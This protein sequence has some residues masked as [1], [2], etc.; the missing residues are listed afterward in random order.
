M[1]IE[2]FLVYKVSE[3]VQKH[4][5][6]VIFRITTK[7][8]LCDNMMFIYNVTE[9]KNCVSLRE[10]LLD[11]TFAENDAAAYAIESLLVPHR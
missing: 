3:A 10:R 8:S 11:V 6:S 7:Q 5:N 1:F 9:V 4:W 2:Y